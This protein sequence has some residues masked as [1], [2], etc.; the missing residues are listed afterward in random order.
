MN[1]MVFLPIAVI[2]LINFQFVTAQDWLQVSKEELLK[3]RNELSRTGFENSMSDIVF[4]VDTSESLSD[5][6]YNEEAKFVS[7]L[8]NEISVA[9]DATRV[10]V[11]PFG[12]TA[13]Q[14]ITQIS[15]PATTKNKCTF[16]EKFKTMSKDI[17]GGWTNIKEAF[18]LASKV[19]LNNGLKRVPLSLVRTVV[20]LLTD[21]K[22]NRPP[23][24]PSPVSIAQDMINGNVEVFAIG[25]GDKID[26]DNLKLVV[27]DPDKKAFHLNDFEEFAELA[28]YIRGGK[29]VNLFFNSMLL[30]I[31]K[32]MKRKALNEKQSRFVAKSRT[33]MNVRVHGHHKTADNRF[34]CSERNLRTE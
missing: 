29:I 4:L 15:D 31:V 7:N 22:W 18:Q 6:D 26:Y 20:I 2:L 28:T 23:N 9:N 33:F 1:R 17:I 12:T 34:V 16:N 21:G 3:L 30:K 11:I 24:D 13:S 19:C 5:D 14:F 10:E 27:E 32:Q 8:L 25:I